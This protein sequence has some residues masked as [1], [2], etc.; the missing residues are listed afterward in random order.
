MDPFTLSLAAQRPHLQEGTDQEHH[1]QPAD[2]LL[3][4]RIVRPREPGRALRE[5]G[6][7]FGRPGM[8]CKHTVL[9]V[10]RIRRLLRYS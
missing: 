5:T 8:K 1:E 2:D 4:R 7:G 9:R 10:D 3:L 6:E